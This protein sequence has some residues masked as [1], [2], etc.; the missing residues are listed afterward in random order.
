MRLSRKIYSLS[1]SVATFLCA[2][3]LI[4]AG[5]ASAVTT[6]TPTASR[7]PA[8]EHSALAELGITAGRGGWLHYTKTLVG[9]IGLQHP[10]TTTI[11]GKHA[12]GGG[13]TFPSSQHT[14]TP[15]SPY[16]Y[17]EETGYNP[18]TCQEIIV[19]G[20]LTSAG[21]AKLNTITQGTRTNAP[22]A[23][24]AAGSTRQALSS[25]SSAATYSETAFEKN[26]W[27]DPL[28]ITIVSLAPNISWK[29]NGSVITSYSNAY[30]VPYEFKYD[31]WSGGNVSFSWDGCVGCVNLQLNSSSSWTNTDFEEIIVALTGGSGYA[32]CG[33]NSNP[34]T[35]KLSPFI[36]AGNNGSFAYGHNSPSSATGGCSDLVH[37]RENHGYGNGS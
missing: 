8:A 29:A 14:A 22:A 7:I 25:D 5:S 11:T 26:S 23:P 24:A 1:A 3:S 36:R 30:A 13:C 15:G 27:V 31:G 9:S 18:G 17:S 20:T 6:S 12:S 28:D 21:E 33:F 10:V 19:S 2:T 37:F 35:F 4:S 32:A 16:G 34:A